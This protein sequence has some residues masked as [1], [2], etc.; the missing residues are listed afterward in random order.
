MFPPDFAICSECVAE[1]LDRNSRFYGYHWNSC[2]FCGPRFSMLYRPPYDRENTSMIHFPLC[3]DCAR[4]YADPG[5]LRRFHAQGISCPACGP[6]TLVYSISGIRLDVD[7]AVD[8]AAEKILEHG[9]LAIKGI[10]GTTSPAWPQRTQLC[11]SSGGGR[12]G[13]TSRSQSWRGTI[14]SWRK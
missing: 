14:A 11:W 1:A 5:S 9:I 3:G 4:E 8:F 7:D 2:A 13:R 12:G 6:K 10:G